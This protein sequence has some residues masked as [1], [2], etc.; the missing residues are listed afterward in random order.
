MGKAYRYILFLSL[1]ATVAIFIHEWIYDA[2]TGPYSWQQTMM[3]ILF[4]GSLFTG[5]LFALG[6][7]V[8]FVIRKMV[9]ALR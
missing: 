8:Y 1:L 3:D 7:G 6:S 4:F 9:K 5:I 2:P